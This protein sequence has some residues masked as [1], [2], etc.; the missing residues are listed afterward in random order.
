M[1]PP[2][3]LTRWEE[4]DPEKKIETT[5]SAMLKTAHDSRRQAGLDG[6]RRLRRKRARRPRPSRRSIRAAK[7]TTSPLRRA[8]PPG[9]HA[10]EAARRENADAARLRPADARGFPETP[11]PKRMWGLLLRI[12][13]SCDERMHLESFRH[14]HGGS[15]ARHRAEPGSVSRRQGSHTPVNV[16]S[17]SAAR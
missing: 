12:T 9:S 11:A 5:L 7:P 13:A 14:V 3:D 4:T 10:G 1:K 2:A 17:T 16:A 8:A 6:W 15:A